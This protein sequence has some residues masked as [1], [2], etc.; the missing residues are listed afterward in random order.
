MKGLTKAV[1]CVKHRGGWCA[2]SVKPDE[3]DTSVP[4]VCGHFV[5]MPWGTS[6]REPTCKECRTALLALEKQP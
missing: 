2:A 5:I 3:A 1:R 4:T 6:T